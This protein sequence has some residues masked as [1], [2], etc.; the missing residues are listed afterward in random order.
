[1]FCQRLHVLFPPIDLRSTI[2]VY[3]GA[4]KAKSLQSMGSSKIQTTWQEQSCRASD[5]DSEEVESPLETTLSMIRPTDFLQ[6]GT[7]R[8]CNLND[9]YNFP[10][11][12]F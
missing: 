7:G 6:A 9:H 1:M 2:F 5:S 11:F 12:T 8:N 3:S 10:T 4:C